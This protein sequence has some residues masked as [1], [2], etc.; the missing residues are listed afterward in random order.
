MRGLDVHICENKK[1]DSDGELSGRTQVSRRK[2]DDDKPREKAQKGGET[3]AGSKGVTRSSGGRKEGVVGVE[4]GRIEAKHWRRGGGLK[5]L[6]GDNRACGERV[7][8]KSFSS[9][10]ESYRAG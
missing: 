1:R 5:A 8:A 3:A 4:G 6:W 7:D 9:E 10:R 2:K